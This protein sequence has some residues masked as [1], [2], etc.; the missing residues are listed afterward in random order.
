MFKFKITEEFKH[1]ATMQIT[2]VKVDPDFYLKM[3]QSEY[4]AI[5]K[6]VGSPKRVLELGCGLGRM[7]IFLNHKLKDST[8]F[9]LADVSEESDKIRYGWDPKESYYN[10]LDLTAKFSEIHGLT[11][12]RTFNLLSEDLRSLADIDLV[13]SFLSVGFHYPIDQYFAKLLDITSDDCTMIFG[14]RQGTCDLEKYKK[15]FKEVHSVPN[16]I[17]SKETLL[18]MKGKR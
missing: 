11:N 3:S 2:Q 18:I 15:F 16:S 10:S 6:H 8:E 9:I 7:S 5:K 13:M 17:A 4:A 14:V 1:Y 12:Y